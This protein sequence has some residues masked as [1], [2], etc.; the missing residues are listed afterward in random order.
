MILDGDLILSHLLNILRLIAFVFH[1]AAVIQY[2]KFIV[3]DAVL[4]IV[5]FVAAAI[6]VDVIAVGSSR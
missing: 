3:A 4:R 6:Q 1:V 2:G 5:G